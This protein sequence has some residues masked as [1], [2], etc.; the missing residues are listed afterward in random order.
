MRET[1]SHRHRASY[2][3]LNPIL[4]HTEHGDKES[5]VRVPASPAF[6]PL[7]LFQSRFRGPHRLLTGID[8]PVSS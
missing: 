7:W 6:A 2:P 1:G 4:N 5:P 3:P 8:E